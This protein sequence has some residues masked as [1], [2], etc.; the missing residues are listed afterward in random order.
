MKVRKRLPP[1]ST[2]EAPRR[3]VRMGNLL[4]PPLTLVRTHLG[5]SLSLD[6]VEEPSD[7]VGKAVADDV[8]EDCDSSSEA[9]IQEESKQRQRKPEARRARSD[10]SPLRAPAVRF[11]GDAGNAGSDHPHTNA[12]HS[13]SREA[14]LAAR[15]HRTHND[16]VGGCH[17]GQENMR[18]VHSTVLRRR[19]GAAVEIK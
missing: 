13:I 8:D 19:A 3:L 7:I 11:S 9:C 6:Q 15:P 18:T 14:L 4:A 10:S 12:P 1:N 16:G 5:Q 2:S 17:A